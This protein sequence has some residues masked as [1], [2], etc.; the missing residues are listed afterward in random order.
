MKIYFQ[1]EENERVDKAMDYAKAFIDST[2]NILN[3]DDIKAVGEYL[4]LYAEHK[5]IQDFRYNAYGV[6]KKGE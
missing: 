6:T 3:V 1:I 2:L 4:V 5:K